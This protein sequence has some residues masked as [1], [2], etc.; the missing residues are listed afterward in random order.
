[1]VA[2][3][4]LTQRQKAAV[5]VRLLLNEDDDGGLNLA[6]LTGDTQGLLAQEMAGMRLVDR[7]TRDAV[8]GEFCNS[9]EAVGVTFPGGL[10]PTLDMLGARISG[11]T[12]ERLRQ[13]SALSGGSDP[14]ARLSML[15]QDKLNRLAQSEAVEIVALMMSMLPV[16]KASAV[17]SALAADRARA[18][19][20]AMSMTA[21]VA[22]PALHRV[23]LVLLNAAEALPRPALPSPVADRVGT[24]L[25]FATA[26]MRDSV[27]N[28]LEQGDAVFASGVRRAIF[29]FAHIPRRIDP[30]EVPRI[31]REVEQDVLVRALAL[32]KG[33]TAEPDDSAAAD[34]I[35]S[36]LSQRMAEGL[37][38]EI[39]N[40]GTVRQSDGDEAMKTMITA[41]RQL[42]VEGEITLLLP[43]ED[44]QD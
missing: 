5:I 42:E 12:T 19:A 30:R 4:Q 24:L 14:W 34:F 10:D 22:A 2:A 23:G 6:A 28:A 39:Q 8:I 15:D 44:V 26:D 31:V 9:L 40:A 32:A 33:P 41:I 36:S 38:D 20:Q 13:A 43:D 21:D 29:T 7:A 1:M 27:L 18:I 35:L 25:N 17:F 11:D 3:Q 16:P 37:R